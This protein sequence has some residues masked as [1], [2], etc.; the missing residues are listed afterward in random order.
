MFLSA[1]W[2]QQ[3]EAVP[4]PNVLSNDRGGHR[5]ECGRDSPR[6]AHAALAPVLQEP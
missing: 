1:H 5:G 6:S 2:T 3:M 4:S